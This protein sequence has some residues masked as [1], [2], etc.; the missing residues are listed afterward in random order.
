ML[1]LLYMGL[2]ASGVGYLL[3]NASVVR[4]GPTRTTTTVHGL[5]PAWVAL[6]AWPALGE[7]PT[8]ITL[9]SAMLIGVGLVL[10]LSELGGKGRKP[11]A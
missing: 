1:G 6:L 8:G 7:R 2:V 10:S 11:Q 9:V 3:Y 5:V 4:L